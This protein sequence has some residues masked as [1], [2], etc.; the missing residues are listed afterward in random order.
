MCIPFF[1]TR[2]ISLVLLSVVFCLSGCRSPKQDALD[3]FAKNCYAVDRPEVTRFCD[4]M[5]RRLDAAIPAEVFNDPDQDQFAL[6][7][8]FGATATKLTPEC[9]AEAEPGQATPAEVPSPAP[10]PP[11]EVPPPVEAESTGA[12]TSPTFVPDAGWLAV[13]KQIAEAPQDFVKSCV[14]GY[15]QMANELGDISREAALAGN[16]SLEKDCQTRLVDLKNC[17]KLDP[18]ASER[19]FNAFS[20]GQE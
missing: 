13:Q 16:P 15:L 11:A 4:C 7:R 3:G 17:M 20:Q 6:M 14:E 2:A 9:K 19:C 10:A 1:N 8:A 18:E 12:P 5:V